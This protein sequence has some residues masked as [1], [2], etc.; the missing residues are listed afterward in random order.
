LAGSSRETAPRRKAFIKKVSEKKELLKEKGGVGEV[1]CRATRGKSPIIG[2]LFMPW[3]EKSD[4]E[5]LAARG[6]GEARF[7]GSG[8]REVEK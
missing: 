5:T 6:K 7:A 4:P 2:D 3:E 8:V 1:L